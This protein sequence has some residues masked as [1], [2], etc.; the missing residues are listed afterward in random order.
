MPWKYS[1]C[2]DGKIR[3][4]KECLDDKNHQ[5][6]D[7]EIREALYER[8][9]YWQDKAHIGKNI[10]AT[11]LIGCLRSTYLERV[12]DYIA[13]PK[14][15][16]YSLRGELIHKLVERP[17][18]DNPY[19][20]RES[21]KRLFMELNGITLSGQMDIWRERFLQEGLLK[22]WKSIGD[23][24]LL[25]IIRG[26]AKWEHRWQT[27][28][29]G[30]LAKRN[31]YLFNKIQI[32]YLSLMD[33]VTTGQEAILN[34]F[35]VNPP[36]AKGFRENMISVKLVKEYPSGK[37]KW[38]CTYNV[39][40]VPIFEEDKVIAFIEPRLEILHAAFEKDEI[41]PLPTIQDVDPKDRDKLAKLS[42]IRH[43]YWKCNG[44]CPVWEKCVELTPGWDGPQ[45][46]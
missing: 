34:E 26:G 28:I 4:F 7:L 12:I 35:L 40:D 31:N 17:D 27:N 24:G 14:G 16:W 9:Q 8:E 1:M 21:E 36:D 2:G 38:A 39:P 13:E 41:P 45:G 18:Y 22:D 20:K 29:Y 37:K 6:F 44:Y 5:C 25:Y 33:V 46:E 23:N 43:E 15:Q 11:A 3:T 19:G 32:V 10:S 30:L 42:D